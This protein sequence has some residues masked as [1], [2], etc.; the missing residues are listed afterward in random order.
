[1]SYYDERGLFALLELMIGE[2]ETDRSSIG[3][4][5][6]SMTSQNASLNHS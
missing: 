3:K 4:E 5:I 1:M 2:Y 6:S